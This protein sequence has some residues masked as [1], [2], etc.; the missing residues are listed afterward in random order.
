[1]PSSFPMSWQRVLI[2]VPFEHVTSIVNV[3]LYKSISIISIF[4]IFMSRGFRSIIFPSLASSYSF[5]PFTLSA[6]Y[7][8][9][10]CFMSPTNFSTHSLIFCSLIPVTSYSFKIVPV[11]SCVSVSTPSL[12]TALYDLSLSVRS[13]HTFVA[14]PRHTGSTPV[15]AGSSVPV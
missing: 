15:A 12:H 13:S 8:G 6:E 9:G 4:E 2:Y 3:L 11:M 5:L 7:I 1:M 10:I 14:F